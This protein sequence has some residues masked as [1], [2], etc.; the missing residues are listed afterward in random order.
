MKTISLLSSR[1]FLPIFIVQF[2]G[3][4]ND[5]VFRFA[6][7]TLISYRLAGELG[8]QASVLNITAA[9]IF[10]LPFFLFSGTGGLLA[11]KYQK[12]LLIRYI[13]LFEIVI[14]CLAAIAFTNNQL[15]LLLLCLGMTGLQSALFGPVKYGVLPSL[16]KDDEL[17]SGNALFGAGTFL[18][19]LLG[20]IVGGLLILGDNGQWQVSAVLITCAC[21]G[22]LAS[23]LIPRIKSF[24][25]EINPGFNIFKDSFKVF[26]IGTKKP[27]ISRIILGI[28]WFW[29]LG[30]VIHSQLPP[31]TAEVLRANEKVSVILLVMFTIGIGAGSLVCSRVMHGEVSAR[32]VPFAAVLMSIFTFDLFYATN[33]MLTQHSHN[34]LYDVASFLKIPVSWRILADMFLLSMAAG[35]YIVPLYTLL[36][37]RAE[38]ATRSRTIA[39]NNI[40]NAFFMVLA[41]LL[42]LGALKA[43]YKNPDLFWMLATLNMMVAFYI[44]KLIPRQSL[45]TIARILLKLFYRVEVKGIDNF[46]KEKVPYVIVSNH[47]SFLDGPLLMSFLPTDP[48]FAINTMANEKW[49]ANIFTR[50]FEMFPLDSGK[51]MAIKGL[52][53]MLREGRHVVIFPEGRISLTGRLMKMYE[54]AG[55]I[56][57]MGNAGIIPVRIEGAEYSP[58]SRMDRAIRR[59]L[60]PKITIVICPP[61]K[62]SISD[63]VRGKARREILRRSVYN[64][65]THTAYKTSATDLT[66]YESLHEAIKVYGGKHDVLED[67][68]RSPANLQRVLLGSVVLGR[69]LR[70]HL[71]GENIGVM[72]PNAVGTAITFYSLQYLGAVAAMV[73]FT[74]GVESLR[75][76]L[77]AANIKTILTSKKFIKLAQLEHVIS[78]INSQVKVVYL[79]DLKTEITLSDKIKGM[80]IAKSRVGLLKYQRSSQQPAVVLFTS[81][82][83]GSPKGV[84]LSHKNL[85]ANT[86]Q[87]RASI[88]FTPKDRFFNAL[89]VFHSFGLGV[90][91][92]LPV[93]SGIRTFLY[94]SPLHYKIIPE[95]IYDTHSTVMFGTDTFLSGYAKHA[96]PEDFQSTRY[97]VAGAEKLKTATKQ[98]WM[99]RFGVRIFEGYGVTETSPALSINTYSYYKE[100]TVGRF[101]PGIRYKLETVEGIKQGGR[102]WVQGENVMMGYLKVDRPG[103]LQP[104]SDGWHDTGDIVDIDEAGFISILGRAKRFAK[105]GGEMVSLTQVESWIAKLWPTEQHCICAVADQRKGE[106]LVL[107]TTGQQADRKTLQDYI[108]D[109]GGAELMVPRDIIPVTEIPLLGSGKLNYPA[110]QKIANQASSINH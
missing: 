15:G 104:T 83:E 12:H 37:K 59:R 32:Y 5:N 7:L 6:L 51:P 61:E 53:K 85:L 77:R 63:A 73:N 2:L 79:E 93:T 44:M 23:L 89:P 84:V 22:G 72:L 80:L 97:V 46:P 17:L 9:G 21:I 56:A 1:N 47:V 30:Y 78:A 26:Q 106:K 87:V 92:V 3:A 16:L 88:D 90:G 94:P 100:G 55:K 110:I 14:M 10:I 27:E 35:F 19:I 66:L 62:I 108:I 74:M 45:K 43:G 96:D 71:V 91:L 65:M 95:L 40:I 76:S 81:G 41:S 36:Q 107:V 33:I 102:L 13:K 20:T 42:V 105:I 11:D 39:A 54:G 38:D 86:A 75:S 64:I 18:S 50:F 60:F 34:S 48:V 25:P 57:D 68:E 4:F 8:V 103:V 70:S 99:N 82:S 98:L 101:L 31:L 109:Q 67:V 69:A 52:I 49:W 29:F 24:A 28:S 58:F